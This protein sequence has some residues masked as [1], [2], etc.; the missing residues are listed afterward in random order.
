MIHFSHALY[1]TAENRNT[2]EQSLDDKIDKIKNESCRRLQEL[3][4]R[5]NTRESKH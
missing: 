1:C 2:L 3:N 5:R 4:E